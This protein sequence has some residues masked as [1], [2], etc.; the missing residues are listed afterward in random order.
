MSVGFGVSSLEKLLGSPPPQ[1]LKSHQS[2]LLTLVIARLSNS[3]S[4]SNQTRQQL[5]IRV[6]GERP[7]SSRISIYCCCIKKLGSIKKALLFQ[8]INFCAWESWVVWGTAQRDRG[9]ACLQLSM[10]LHFGLLCFCPLLSL[11]GLRVPGKQGTL[12]CLGPGSV[13]LLWDGDIR[14]TKEHRYLLTHRHQGLGSPKRCVTVFPPLL[15]CSA[16]EKDRL[17]S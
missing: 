8:G 5:S 2:Q 16:I 9:R 6:A 14:L 11:Y 12:L 4:K 1:L 3:D 15:S 13:C 10:L 17:V 7:L